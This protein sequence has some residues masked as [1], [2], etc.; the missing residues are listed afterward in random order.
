MFW[1]KSVI[2]GPKTNVAIYKEEERRRKIYITLIKMQ[3]VLKFELYVCLNE[4][5]VFN[6][7]HLES[8]TQ[9][10]L[11]QGAPL[12]PKL[13]AFFPLDHT[14]WMPYYLNAAAFQNNL[15]LITSTT[16]NWGRN[17]S[18]QLVIAVSQP[19][20]NFLLCFLTWNH[21]YH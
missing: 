12:H 11:E 1:T 4:C 14:I 6:W 21:F 3:I 15:D 19:Q 18:V 17:C 13:K 8:A 5:F 2:I 16:K 10:F 7:T 20:K 9:F